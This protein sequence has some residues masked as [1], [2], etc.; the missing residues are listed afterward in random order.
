MS[1]ELRAIAANFLRNERVDH[2][3]QPTAL[4][5]EAYLRLVDSTVASD[6]DR[7]RFMGLAA[8]AMRRVLVDHARRKAAQRRGGDV[9]KRVSLD[10]DLSPGEGGELDLVELNDLLEKYERL[11]ERACRVV[12]LH[13]FAGLSFAETAEVLQVT[14]RTVYKD[15]SMARVWLAQ[16]MRAS[17][18]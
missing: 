18:G 9:W 12:E 11:D 10:P 15:W 3:L 4:V 6:T 8:R 7:Q 13:F 16:Q 5:H 1:A 17:D 14:E 2:T